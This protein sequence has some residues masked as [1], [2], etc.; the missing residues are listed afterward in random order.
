M[1]TGD[2]R[3][4]PFDSTKFRDAI[5]FA[6]KMGLPGTASERVTFQWDPSNT[7]AA[8]D[9]KGNPYDWTSS[10][11]ASV[12]AADLV[13]SL[14]LPAAVEYTDS[15]SSSG[16]TTIGDFDKGRIKITILDTQYALITDGD[17]GLPDSVLVDGNTYNV[18]YFIPPTALFDVTVYSLYCTARDES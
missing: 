13:A 6:M 2:T 3:Q 15:K 8:A 14:A 4:G 10:P 11:T 1:D 5:G 9:Q 16:D 18:D 7:Y 17:L 12:T